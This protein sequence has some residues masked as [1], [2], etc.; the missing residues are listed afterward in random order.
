MI[1]GRRIDKE[2]ER[3]KWNPQQELSKK[4]LAK[5]NW[6]FGGSKAA[7]PIS[8]NKHDFLNH[9]ANYDASAKAKR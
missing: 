9:G 6:S 7:A 8:Q 4:D 1:D 2:A 5:S 3:Q